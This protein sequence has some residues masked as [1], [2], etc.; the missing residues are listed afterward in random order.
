MARKP[1]AQA[2]GPTIPSS[3][4]ATSPGYPLLSDPDHSDQQHQRPAPSAKPLQHPRSNPRNA[5]RAL[6]QNHIP[7]SAR[8]TTRETASSVEEAYSTPSRPTAQTKDAAEYPINRFLARRINIQ[9]LNRG[10]ILKRGRKLVHQIPSPRIPVWL[11]NH[12]RPSKP[13]VLRRPKRSPNL[14][15]M[16]PIIIHYGHTPHTALDLKPPVHAAKIP[17]PLRNRLWRHIQLQSNRNRCRRIQNIVLSRNMQ[18]KRP[19]HL[20][21]GRNLKP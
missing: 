19:Q 17:Q 7:S 6:R 1:Q 5:P 10:S 4:I 18:L 11:E 8:A 3:R 9:N 20:P 14:R 2:K 13:T 16:V 21:I 12:M 15:R